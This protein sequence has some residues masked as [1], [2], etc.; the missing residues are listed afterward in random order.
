MILQTK[1][2]LE[3]GIYMYNSLSLLKTVYFIDDNTLMT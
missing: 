3:F 2:V 1:D